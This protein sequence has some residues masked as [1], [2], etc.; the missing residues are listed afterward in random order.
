MSQVCG[1]ILI[2]VNFTFRLHLYTHVKIIICSS[3][4]KKFLDQ[5]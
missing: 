2:N 3:E 4:L 1:K 5:K